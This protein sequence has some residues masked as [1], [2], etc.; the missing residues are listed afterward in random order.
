MDCNLN[1]R[2]DACEFDCNDSGMPD[3]C[4]ILFEDSID[5]NGN[6]VPDE[7]ECPIEGNASPGTL[8][9]FVECL[10][11]PRLPGQGTLEG[12]GC[13]DFDF[14]QDIDLIDYGLYSRALFPQ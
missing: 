8:P 1:G 6:G 10:S 3:D 9:E 14:D 11:G 13:Y 4:D 2:I 12:C 5:K 7:C